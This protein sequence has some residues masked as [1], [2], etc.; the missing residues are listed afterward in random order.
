M[1]AFGRPA[2][3]EPAPM[4]IKQPQ[5]RRHAVCFLKMERVKRIELSRLAW[6]ARALPLS[7]TRWNKKII[8]NKRTG[9]KQNLNF[10]AGRVLSRFTNSTPHP[11]QDIKCHAKSTV[12]NHG[13]GLNHSPDKK[14][15]CNQLAKGKKSVPRHRP[16]PISLM[17]IGTLYNIRFKNNLLLRLSL[18][19]KFLFY[20]FRK[21]NLI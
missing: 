17:H 2:R 9:I 4:P 7:Y 20:F 15:L 6:E 19:P 8:A 18:S 16:C 12:Q 21:A 14:A 5:P 13:I 10:F 1:R 11:R 3:P